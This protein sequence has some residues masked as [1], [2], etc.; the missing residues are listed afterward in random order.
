MSEL[1]LL[2]GGIDSVSVA[3]WKKPKICLTVD[4]GQRSAA[5]E[6]R[7]SS[8]VCKELGLRHELLVARVSELGSGDMSEQDA[9]TL[10][11]H[12]EFWPFRNQYLVTLGAMAAIKYGCDSVLIGTVITDIRHKDGSPEFISLIDKTLTLQEGG[13]RLSAP[14]ALMTSEELVLNSKISDG[15]LAWAHSCH[16]GE[17][18]CGN[19]K[20]C[21]KH[22]EVM[23][24]L[25]WSR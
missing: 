5:A 24:K 25:G 9:K 6:I 7:S 18:A 15:I 10:S 13:I 16:T 11:M 21:Q 19:C 20:G 17:F 12:S 2:S 23:M 4:Y 22:S 1:L 3:A 14:G 8:Q